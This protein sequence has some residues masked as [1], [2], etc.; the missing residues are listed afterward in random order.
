MIEDQSSSVRRINL[1]SELEKDFSYTTGQILSSMNC[2]AEKNAREIFIQYLE[3][4]LGDP[5]LFPGTKNIEAYVIGILGRF[6]DLP[7]NG[8]GLVLAGGSEANITAMWAIRNNERKKTTHSHSHPLEILAPQSAHISI[9]KAIDLLN[10]KLVSIPVTDKYQIDIKKAKRSISSQTIGVVGVAGT[11]AFGTIDPLLELNELCLENGLPLHIDAAFGGMVF[12]FLPNSIDYNLSFELKSLVSMTVDIHKMGRVPIPGGGLLWRDKSYAQAIEFTLPYL[13]GHP[14]QNTLSGTRSGA[15]SVAF[16]Y[17][18]EIL[19]F[20]GFQTE[21]ERCI[22][23]TKFLAGELVKRG[24]K[25][26]N[27]PI[28]NILGVQIPDFSSFSQEEFHKVLWDHGWT[29]SLVNSALR[30][31]I[32]PAT[33]REHLIKLL[34]VIDDLMKEE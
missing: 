18:W 7:E 21:V 4:N 26:P 17:L 6:F 24:F 30:F 23:N 5:A 1:N 13:A 19:G 25:I 33:S 34:H 32:M 8:T 3:S 9:N 29:T 12:P 27:D 14:R 10:L 2:Q 20:K 22:Q 15:S 11:T 31:V 28:I 16:A